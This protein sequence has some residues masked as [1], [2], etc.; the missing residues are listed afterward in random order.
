LIYD[1]DQIIPKLDKNGV[2]YK[3]RGTQFREAL[4][5]GLGYTF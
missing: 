5:I 2:Q 1:H 4:N 3:G